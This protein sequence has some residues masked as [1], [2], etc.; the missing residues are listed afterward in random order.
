MHVISGLFLIG[1]GLNLWEP[2]FWAHGDS[3]AILIA[4]GV[5]VIA[6]GSSKRSS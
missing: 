4:A 2:H 5:V 6:L 1:W 3:G